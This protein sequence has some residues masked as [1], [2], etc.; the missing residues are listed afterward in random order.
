ML[1]EVDLSSIPPRVEMHAADD[2]S[3]LKVRVNRPAHAHIERSEIVRLAGPHGDDETW[4]SDLDASLKKAAEHG[5]AA[6]GSIRAH[7]E[8][9]A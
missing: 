2:V 7:V 8:W 3:T 6:N 1:I 4:L 5:W 9:Q